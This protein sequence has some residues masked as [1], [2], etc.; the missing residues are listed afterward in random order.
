MRVGGVEGGREGTS[1][2]VGFSKSA[3]SLKWEAI[4]AAGTRRMDDENA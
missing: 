4:I 3:L 2:C 1:E